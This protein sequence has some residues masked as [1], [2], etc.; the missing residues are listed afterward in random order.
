MRRCKAHRQGGDDDLLIDMAERWANVSISSST[1]PYVAGGVGAGHRIVFYDAK[2]IG[3]TT[4]LKGQLMTAS[5]TPSGRERA[6]YGAKSQDGFTGA[7]PQPF[8]RQMGPQAMG[9]LAEVVDSGLTCDM[10]GRFETAFA[11]AHGVAHCI[12]TPG[13]TPALAVLA[14]AFGL[15][16]GDEIIVSSISDFGT[17]QG[18]IHAGLIP[19]FADT[20]PGA[21][22]I[23]PA[24]V[25]ACVSDRTRAVL[26]V[27]MTGLICDMDGINEVA[28]RHG[29]VVYEDACQAVFG[30]YKTR[31]AGTLSRAGAFS[32]DSEKTMGSDVGGCILT[33]D[34]ELAERAR[35]V[36]HS[37][38][39]EMVEH[40]GRI[41]AINGFA[42]RMTQ[43]TAA[44]SLA[45]LE[46]I[47]PQVAHIDKMIRLLHRLLDDIPGIAALP[48]PEDVDVYSCWMAGFLIDPA[49]FTCDT[50]SF[51]ERVAAAGI[52]GAS[53]ARYYLLPAA[54]PYLTESA[55][56]QTYP[57]S[58]PPASYTYH[59]GAD[60][61]PQA[62]ALLERYVRWSTFCE[63]YE[64]E[65]CEQA[66]HIVRS[67]AEE[68]RR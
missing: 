33:D 25:E 55:Q 11:R 4:D 39:G 59:Y 32:F 61:C 36:G 52:P 7:L 17:V 45:Q 37:R 2:G 16:P 23:S 63:R 51:G 10:V 58:Q 47:E 29:L 5:T 53:Q 24:T 14:A 30:R 19:V 12:A 31:L 40:F 8:P 38:G 34:D 27:H 43:S 44:I 56:K 21:I 57:Y 18:L 62:H 28:E 48:I 26:V 6:R 66:A 22:N 54:L 1:S 50:E 67:V 15:S 41:H 20:T 35:F 42:H 60:S 46:I 64:P 13:C 9:Y 49:Q 3:H 68:V 65:H